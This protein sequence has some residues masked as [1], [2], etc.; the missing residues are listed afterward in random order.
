MSDFKGKKILITGATG[1]IGKELSKSYLNLG[2]DLVLSGT[3]KKNL[4]LLNK[5]FDI[6]YENNERCYKRND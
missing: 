3:N 4:E 5:E 6:S 1:G 2:A